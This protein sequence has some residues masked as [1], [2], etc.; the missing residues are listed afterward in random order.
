M[1]V[2]ARPLVIRSHPWYPRPSDGP[3]HVQFSRLN[4]TQLSSGSGLWR[5]AARWRSSPLMAQ[6]AERK[7]TD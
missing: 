3:S 6:L 7:T 4:T 2:S 5:P 1:N